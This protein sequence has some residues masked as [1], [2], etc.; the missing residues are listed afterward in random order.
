MTNPEDN[1]KV[2]LEAHTLLFS[3]RRSIQYHNRRRGFYNRYNLL[4]NAFAIIGGSGIALQIFQQTNTPWEG[5][6][7]GMFIVITS[8][9]N[10]VINTVQKIHQHHNLSRQFIELEKKII[11][12]KP[13]KGRDINQWEATKLSIE[14]D[15][16]PILQVLDTICHN[17]L[18]RR[19]DYPESDQVKIGFLQRL[20]SN[21]VDIA[22]HR[23]KSSE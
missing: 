10:L 22:P 20:F 8:T 3:V 13:Y 2:D 16:P 7:P 21:I 23:L 14:S 5:I 15:E 18:L 17:D 19:M 11:T 1:E 12:G 6:V 9:L 4:T